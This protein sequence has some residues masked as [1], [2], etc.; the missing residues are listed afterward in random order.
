MYD[1]KALVFALK[2]VS[3]ALAAEFI[4]QVKEIRVI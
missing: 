4:I 3:V 1:D 2:Y